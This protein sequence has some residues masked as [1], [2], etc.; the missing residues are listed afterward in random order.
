MQLVNEL[1]NELAF[2]VLVEKK[3]GE[4]LESKDVLP[5]IDRI[6]AILEPISEKDHSYSESIDEIAAAST[7]I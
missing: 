3:S 1:E 6:R 2:A 7:D 5:L 4:K